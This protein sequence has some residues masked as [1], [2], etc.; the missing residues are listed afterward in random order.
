MIN[1]NKAQKIL[2]NSKI[3]IR[4]EII[5]TKNVLNRVS[6]TNIYSPVNYPAGNN[7]AFDG[8]AVNS[9]EQLD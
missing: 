7:T 5:F 2:L 9:R 8:Y 6:A 1:Y 3:S 4:N